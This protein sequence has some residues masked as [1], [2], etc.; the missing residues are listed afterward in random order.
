MTIIKNL[1]NKIEKKLYNSPL[2]EI[3]VLFPWFVIIFIIGLR[4]YVYTTYGIE[5]IDEAP[6]WIQWFMD[7]G[8]KW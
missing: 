8:R 5:S 1:I 3:L 2:E 7:G 6:K 4:V